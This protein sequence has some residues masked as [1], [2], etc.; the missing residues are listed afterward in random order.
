M[1]NRKDAF[2]AIAG[3]TQPKVALLGADNRPKASKYGNYTVFIP[4]SQ[5]PPLPPDTTG[6]S[7]FHSYNRR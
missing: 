6:R 3:D 2:A 5:L 1:V 7:R 4:V